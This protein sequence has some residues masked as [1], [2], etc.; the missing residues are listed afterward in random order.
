MS[1][2]FKGSVLFLLIIMI[3]ALFL[4]RFINVSEGYVNINDEF[5][6]F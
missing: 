3:L 5:V 2:T 1:N 6:F 4:A